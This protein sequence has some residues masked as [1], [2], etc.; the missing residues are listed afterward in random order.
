MK[1][2][3]KYKVHVI[4]RK[5]FSGMKN[6]WCEK[7]QYPGIPTEI[8]F[9]RRLRSMRVDTGSVL[10]FY[11]F[12]FHN[13]IKVDDWLFHG[14]YESCWVKYSL[15]DIGGQKTRNKMVWSKLNNIRVSPLSINFP[16]RATW[17]HVDV[18]SVASFALSTFCFQVGGSCCLPIRSKYGAQQN[19]DI[20]ALETQELDDGEKGNFRVPLQR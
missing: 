19:V 10:C 18:R 15:F 14:S 2:S 7:A 8:N 11:C 20:C 17:N 12:M 3:G 6:G 16:T 1:I 13:P 9:L 5:S 4:N